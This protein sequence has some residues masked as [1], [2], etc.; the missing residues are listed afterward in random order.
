MEK[1]ASTV[2]ENELGNRAISPLEMS[3]QEHHL[4]PERSF[5]RAA[6][7][8]YGANLLTQICQGLGDANLIVGQDTET[9]CMTLNIRDLNKAVT[10]LQM[11]QGFE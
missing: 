3:G 5:G 2:M 9:G 6:A 8:H 1:N 7:L 10:G 11:S 4:E